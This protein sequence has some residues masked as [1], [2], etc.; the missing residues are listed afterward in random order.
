MPLFLEQLG[1]GVFLMKRRRLQPPFQL[2]NF[3]ER[4]KIQF[5]QGDGRLFVF[6]DGV[7][8][9]PKASNRNL[10]IGLALISYAFNRNGDINWS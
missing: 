4:P 3:S 7:T 8:N 2:I 9:E 6:S 10:S 1:I 5:P